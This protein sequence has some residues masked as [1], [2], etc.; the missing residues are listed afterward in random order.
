MSPA[1]EKLQCPVAVGV[2][3][4]AFGEQRACFAVAAGV[5]DDHVQ[6]LGPLVFQDF[7][8]VLSA[9][10]ILFCSTAMRRSVRK[11]RFPSSVRPLVGS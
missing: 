1:V 4:A 7:L 6:A 9:P 3:D 5:H 8:G 10:V 2:A 11:Y